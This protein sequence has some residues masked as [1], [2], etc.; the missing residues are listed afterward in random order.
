MRDERNDG[1]AQPL[2]RA[3]Q[4]CRRA[5]AVH[6]VIA[7]NENRLASANRAHDAV[8]RTIEI[9]ERRR[10]VQVLETRAEIPLRVLDFSMSARHEQATHELGKVQLATQRRDRVKIRCLREKPAGL[11][12]LWS[13]SRCGHALQA[14]TGTGHLQSLYS[15]A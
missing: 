15:A 1:A 8:D 13:N 12:G 3:R 2:Q 4:D 9:A 7:V 5:D 14:R 10:I 11:A 6:I